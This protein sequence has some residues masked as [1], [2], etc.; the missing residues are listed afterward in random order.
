[1]Q[2]IKDSSEIDIEKHALIEASAGT[3]KTFI[4]ENIVARLIVEEGVPLD[5]ILLVTF[6]EKATGELRKR[7]RERIEIRMRERKTSDDE[8]AL[9]ENALINFDA[10]SI[11]TIH[12]FCHSILKEYSFENSQLFDFDLVSDEPLYEKLLYEQ[13]H[14]SWH[15]EYG[16]GLAEVI[17]ISGFPAVDRRK[18][19][20]VWIRK[21]LSVA[22][23]FHHTVGGRILPEISGDDML[24]VIRARIKSRLLSVA[25]MAGFIDN[26]NPGNSD[27]VRAYEGLNFHKSRK[28]EKLQ[29]V[30]IPILRFLGGLE[31]DGGR[32][33]LRDILGV[34]NGIELQD[35]KRRGMLCLVP[36]DG[37]WKKGCVKNLQEQCPYLEEM[38]AILHAVATDAA[39]ARHIL[40]VE[41]IWRL[42]RDVS[43]YKRRNGLISFSDMLLLV[44]HAL[45]DR[46][47][48]QGLVSSLRAKY[49]YAVVD[50]FQDTDAVQWQIFSEIFM[51]G[52]GQRLFL[53]GDPKQAIY[54]FRGADIYVYFKAR[55]Q[56]SSLACAD[57]AVLYSLDT[58][59]RSCAG[60][61]TVF[62]HLFGDGGW[63]AVGGQGADGGDDDISYTGV[64]PSGAIIDRFRGDAGR[65][66]FTAVNLDASNS[67]VA[68]KR[69]AVF[70]AG[71]IG[72][73]VDSGRVVD[74]CPSADGLNYGDIAILVRNILEASAVER[75]LDAVG[76]PHTFYRKPGLYQSDEAMELLF[77][78]RSIETPND[79]SAMKK[80]LLTPF[81]DM[82]VEALLNPS[83]LD[84]AHA[85]KSLVLRWR[86][87]ALR[88]AW[89]AL[90]QSIIDDSGLLVRDLQRAEGAR[91]MT[92]YRHILQNVEKV[93]YEQNL[94]IGG[95]VG[96]LENLRLQRI[97]VEMDMGMHQ[98]ESER[99]MVKIM[100]I[101]SSKGLEYQVV[102]LAGG[103]TADPNSDFYKY[104]DRG[105]V[106]Y[107]LAGGDAAL[108]RCRIE[109]EGED[110]RLYY[111]AITRAAQRVYVPHYRPAASNL[112]KAGPVAHFIYD[113][114]ESMRNSLGRA[115]GDGCVYGSCGGKG[116]VFVDP[117][118][119]DAVMQDVQV[120]LDDK[121]DP[122]VPERR[123]PPER[124]NFGERV[125]TTESFTS[126]MQR[127]AMAGSAGLM[128]TEMAN[129]SD[130]AVAEGMDDDGGRG[131]RTVLQTQGEVDVQGLPRG[132]YV[133]NMFHE[134]LEVIDFAAISKARRSGQS[135]GC[136]MS[137]ADAVSMVKE[138]MTLHR[139][140]D[141]HLEAVM[142]IV[143]DTL[144]TPI[145]EVGDDFVISDLGRESRT[146]ELEFYYPAN[147]A[148]D[149]AL[150]DGV[151]IND[152][153]YTGFI[154]MVFCWNGRY[155]FA[156]WK[157]NYI[158][159]GYSREMMDTVMKRSNYR[160][161]SEIY[162]EAMRLWLKQRCGHDNNH[163]G[164]FGGAFYL[165]IRGM[166]CGGGDG[167]YY[168]CPDELGGVCIVAEA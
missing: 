92:N 153:F 70:I 98:I 93:A 84:P 142:K 24:D 80:G 122:G 97:E 76:I 135:Y 72:R 71:E 166:G 155:Y 126:I 31:S 138:R 133:G 167:I 55:K 101:H 113:A 108:Q 39:L 150:P 124:F 49:R 65:A 163:E 40:A 45:T 91:R 137:D 106:V 125:V 50:E 37:E 123:L 1:M 47:T 4:I 129:Y 104:H 3:G 141:D 11:Y 114:L 43:D 38:A 132:R 12:G 75:E 94:D 36:K 161:Q 105:D 79:E 140:D 89:S 95:V 41:S 33:D 32:F 158:D 61:I 44:Y 62:N 139:I 34:L 52:G 57:K 110:R 7:I 16:D 147:I 146:H 131:G 134:I 143:W 151:Y 53:I 128:R 13:L 127:V 42:G 27:M 136:L 18:M 154:D 90:F 30:I 20:S 152:G 159:D 25:E 144:T 29:S 88:R 67:S 14:R 54:G 8:A 19:E 117:E 162:A 60:L 82:P 26:D 78:L 15:N 46:R 6:T 145:S 103:F 102:F 77:I 23:S 51:G 10:A 35:Y 115:E 59:W 96:Y 119:V 73:I 22:L 83:L 74:G 109:K 111:V 156:D 64:V 56:F 157:S 160:L 58:N 5:Q 118:D 165:F 121:R 81:F 87:Y 112:S 17:E 164:K 2:I 63:F 120:A 130:F 148:E 100:T 66:P 99:S 86:D 68:K 21:A 48:G 168:L 116:V 85:A 149:I 69:F 107:D 28:R 9:L